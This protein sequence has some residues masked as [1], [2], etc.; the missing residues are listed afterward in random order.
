[1]IEDSVTRYAAAM[2]AGDTFPP[3]V[4]YMSG[5]KVVLIDGNNRDAAARRASLGSIKAYVLHPE[6]PSE[7]IHLMTVDA[8]A[9]HGVTPSLTWRLT[10]ANFLVGIGF[11]REKACTAAAVTVRQL[12][13]YQSSVRA[14]QRAKALKVGGDFSKLSNT[15]KVTLGSLQSDPVFMQAS[16]VAVDTSMKADEIRDFVRE[17]KSCRD[18]STMID[19][20]VKTA[21]ARRL[22]A[23]AVEALGR[24]AVIKSPKQ[25]LIT[26]LGKIAHAEPTDIARCVITDSEREELV[27]RCYEASEKLLQITTALENDMEVKTRAS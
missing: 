7:T 23:A 8:N 25:G 26:G 17:V 21:T 4:G 9:H 10:Q 27:R 11:T 3:V 22:E 18:E 15:A 24:G 6:T 14:D 16:R 20:I 13:D 12:S 5:Q 2:K 1:V 19:A